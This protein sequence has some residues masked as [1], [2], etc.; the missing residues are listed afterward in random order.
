MDIFFADSEAIPLPPSEVRIVQLQATPTS[1][2]KKVRVFLAVTPFQVKPNAEIAILDDEKNE[3][4]SISI[5]ES[6][7]PRMEVTIHLPKSCQARN[8]HLQATIYYS[9]FEDENAAQGVELS[10]QVVDRSSIEITM[11]SM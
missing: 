10:R 2:G 8:L 3:L 5:I 9:H 6:I 1:D 4:T 11:P 7:L